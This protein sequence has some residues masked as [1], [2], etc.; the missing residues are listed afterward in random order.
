M[1]ADESKFLLCP[2][3]RTRRVWRRRGEPRHNEPFVNGTEPFGGGGLMVWGAIS[4]QTRSQLVIIDGTLNSDGYCDILREHVRPL[5]G[6]LDPENLDDNARPHRAR[7]VQE[8][9]DRETIERMEWPAK[10]PDLNPIE[11]VWGV[12]KQQLSRRLLPQHT[13]NDLWDM[14]LEE[15]NNVPIRTI[16][17]FIPSMSRRI[18]SC[19]DANGGYTP[20]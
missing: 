7:I 10:S 11:N 16:R 2:V 17:Q 20:Y 19:I 4:H 3:D 18:Q 14:L 15:W 12:M 5:A 9:M 1:F 13:I 6:A 8:Y